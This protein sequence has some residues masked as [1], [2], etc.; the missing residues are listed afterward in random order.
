M[1]SKKPFYIL[2][3]LLFIA[4]IA[5]S[6]Y[7]GIEHNVPFLPGEQVQSWAV[8]AKVS[9]QGTGKPAE[10]TFSLPKDP[11]FEIL[12][13]N[14]TS[15]GYGMSVTD[16]DVGRQVTWSTREAIG[17]QDLYYKVTLVPTG[18]NEILADSEPDAPQ[19]YNWPAT[20]LAAAEQVMSEIWS[21]SATNLSFAQQLNKSFNAT[22]RSQNLELLLT[23]N[24]RA[25]L[26]I[27][28]LNSKGI[29][30]KKVSGL[31]LED[32]RRRQQ[33]TTYVEVYHQGQWI[34][35]NPNDG[36]QGRPDNLLIWDRTAKSTLDVVGGVNSQVNFSM[37]QDTRSALATS[38]DMLKN[39]DAL[40]FS[41][42]QLPLEEQS[43]FKGILLIPIGVLMVVFLRV[44]IGIKTSG[45][46]MPVLIALAFIQTTLL[47]GLVGFLLIVAFGLM[48][49]SYLSDLNLLLISRI[50]AVIIVVIGIIGL[51]TLL[52]YKFGLSEGLTITFFPMII[53]A[54]TIERMSILWEEEGAKEVMV[55][56]GGS[57]F[58]ATLA[59]L[60]M[61]AHWVQHWV[62]NF[63]GI[64]L[65]ILA[66][67][68]LMGQYTG[69]KLLE[70]RRFRPLAGE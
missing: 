43:L 42:Y 47:T 14:A 70:L 34:I 59:Y 26:F 22:E 8:D 61:S 3:A 35:F 36:S 30:A 18:K 11:A 4:G 9:F 38:I 16:G 60:A 52:S 24:S 62:F 68:L 29:P 64:H 44:I 40:D 10:V 17:Q 55:Q 54:W 19:A 69:Y 66:V 57:L 56:G 46:F 49:R 27:R 20:E 7:R 1:H 31:F 28:M 58:V 23:S 39:K 2:V 25:D 37:L 65:V 5:A 12:V 41:L 15:P 53:L 21:R 51:F 48:I 32:Q 63:L 45:T 13:E 6:V 67:V 50:S 33:L